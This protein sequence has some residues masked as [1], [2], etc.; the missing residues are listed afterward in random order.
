[1]TTVRNKNSFKTKIKPSD[2]MSGRE[3]LQAIYGAQKEQQ[4]QYSYRQLSEDLGFNKSNLLHLIIQ[5]KRPITTDAADKI[6]VSLGLKAREKSYFFALAETTRAKS[7][8]DI[9]TCVA[10]AVAIR[11]G[12]LKT[13]LDRDKFAYYS[14]W[15]HAVIREMFALEGFVKDAKWI[16]SRI[17]PRVSV[18]DVEESLTLLEKLNLIV[19]DQKEKK[20]IQTNATLLTG[21]DVLDLSVASY[22]TASI[23]QGLAALTNF[24]QE[25]RHISSLTLCLSDDQIGDVKKKIQKFQEELL[26]LEQNTGKVAPNNVI[27]LNMQLFP[28]AKS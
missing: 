14:H 11:A 23:P 15:W 7:T 2:Y 12:A 6:A 20:W 8:A 1:M 27:Q 21:Q 22:H 5:G 19:Y 26:E 10:N 18:K 9:K 24:S 13:R 3:F 28:S 16:A 17:W 4:G 25:E